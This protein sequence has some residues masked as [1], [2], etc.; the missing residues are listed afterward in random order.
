M[1]QCM[2][3]EY[4]M[5]FITLPV[6]KGRIYVPEEDVL[7]FKKHSCGS[8]FSCQMCSDDRCSICLSN[9]TGEKSD[10]E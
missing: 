9:A 4:Q 5:P 8:C 1:V 3:G 2:L 10:S 7:F 6:I